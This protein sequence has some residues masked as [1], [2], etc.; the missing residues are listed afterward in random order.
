MNAIKISEIDKKQ[1]ITDILGAN[2]STA[3]SDYAVISA[4]IDYVGYVDDAVTI[5][6]LLPSIS[7][8]MAGSST[9]TTIMSGASVAGII[10]FPVAQMINVI[11][12]YNTG[13]KLYSY[14]CIAY[15]VTAWSFNQ[16]IPS[17]SNRILTNMRTTAPVRTPKVIAEHKLLWS[18]TSKLCLSMLENTVKEKKIKK[19]H[20][21]LVFRALGGGVD[22]QLCLKILKGYEKDLSTIEKLTW[23]SLYK[24]PYPM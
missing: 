14:R 6:E 4:I 18:K 19:E 23:K 7:A 1:I 5:A 17:G 24:I 3:G 16:P 22:R 15:T 11:N 21:Q 9:F 2:Y 20:L 13:H 10:L 12:A 8:L